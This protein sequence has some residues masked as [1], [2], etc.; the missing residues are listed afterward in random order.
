MPSTRSAL[1]DTDVRTP[2]DNPYNG[3]AARAFWRPAVAEG[4]CADRELYPPR[5]PITRT[6]KVA[7]AGSCFAQHVGRALRARAIDLLD[8]EPAPETLSAAD[9]ARFGYGLYS[10]RYGNIFT[11][12]QLVQ[13]ARQATGEGDPSPITWVRGG[14]YYD[15]LRP[16]V[17]PEGL[18]SPAEVAAHRAWHL[19]R[20]GALL[21]EM[22]V[23]IFTLGLTE[24]W[25][26]R[27]TG[28]AFPSAPGVIAG[29]FDPDTTALTRLT[30]SDVCADLEA[31]LALVERHRAGKPLRMLLTVSPVPLTAT[32]TGAHVLVATAESKAILRAAAG[33]MR[34]RHRAVDYF[35]SYEI[36]A[37]PWNGGL[38]YAANRRSVTPAGIAR[39][40]HTFFASHGLGESSPA[41]PREASPAVSRGA[42][43]AVSRDED[44]VCE[45]ALLEAFGR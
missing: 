28:A 5:W 45:D 9:H 18:D 21:R 37:N 13:L 22:D 15:A 20:V 32:A 2:I 14:R 8:V 6:D 34:A 7:T 26:D 29:R 23:F 42:A 39:V 4:R 19:A 10:A 16:S 35:P 33:E 17:E 1:D 31:F 3:L 25:I 41:A 36:I 38:Y 27:S 24:A 43:G 11:T 30:V 44:T 40:M 12:R